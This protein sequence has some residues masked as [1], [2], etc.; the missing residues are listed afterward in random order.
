[1]FHVSYACFMRKTEGL[2]FPARAV[3]LDQGMN[4]DKALLSSQLECIIGDKTHD[5]QCHKILLRGTRVSRTNY[6]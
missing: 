4:S 3:H 1:M 6:C 5:V 2:V